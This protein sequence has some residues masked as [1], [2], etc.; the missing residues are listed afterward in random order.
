MFRKMFRAGLAVICLLSLLGAAPGALARID[1]TDGPAP[2]A[3]A[4]P[5][6]VVR[7]A[8]DPLASFEGGVAGL[9]GTR[10]A[11]GERLDL[12]SAEAQAYAA[13][14]DGLRTDFKNWLATH[15]TGAAVTREYA[16]VFNGLAVRLNGLDPSLLLAAPGVAAVTPAYH[17]YPDMNV[18]HSLV[19]APDLW[20]AAGGV[21]KA[22]EGI[23]VGV[24]D[25]GIDQ[26]HHF[27]KDSKLKP[28][29]GYPKGD[30][31]FTSSKVIVARVFHADPNFTPE[32]VN[33]HGTHVAG[34]IAGVYL[35]SSSLTGLAAPPLT[36]I[37]PK[38]FLGNYNVFPGDVPS[39]TIDAVIAA[40]EEA[41]IDGMDVINMSL[42]A[43]TQEDDDPL[44]ATVNAAVD[45]GVVMAVSAGNS[46]PGFFTVGTPAIAEKAISVA[47]S[48]NPHF[49]GVSV[50]V[51]GPGTVPDDL[52]ANP[53]ATGDGGAELHETAEAVY[54]DWDAIDGLG[55]GEACEPLLFVGEPPLAGKIALIRRGTCFFSTKINNAAAAGA[56]AVI[57]SNNVDGDPVGMS[58]AEP[59][60]T[61]AVMVALTVGRRLRE[62]YAAN[63]GTAAVRINADT[64]E[65]MT[66]N[67]DVIA[68]FSSRGPTPG[69][70]LKPDLA[71]PGVDIYS[72]VVGGGFAAF[73]GTSM[74][75]PH[76]A[77]AAAVLRQVYPKWSP[78]Q[79]KSALVNTAV[80]VRA[81][82]MPDS[83]PAPVLAV[84][85]GRINLSA[86]ADPAALAQPASLG[87]GRV[88]PESGLSAEKVV[89][90]TNPSRSARTYELSVAKSRPS[91]GYSAA[92]DRT[93]VTIAAGGSAFFRVR[94]D[95]PLLMPE[96]DYQG[97][98]TVTDGVRTIRLPFWFRVSLL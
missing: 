48:T 13:Y 93:S 91:D 41:V 10:P 69:Y 95:V 89:L 17:V 83:P 42:G 52:H 94:L 61:P 57:I 25:S 18:S 72:S 5:V 88:F 63:P 38:A 7:L 70:R 23:K 90:L 32:A 59:V 51:L 79:V 28:P 67:G 86:A 66:P 85:G 50:N 53:A 33:S 24:I 8:G 64:S 34:T 36:G 29:K 84:G 60:N 45:A 75:A 31:R 81:D 16:V 68:A 87:F 14:L 65:V 12:E 47:A 11:D 96:G 77:G 98:V 19:G 56:I 2:G 74:A 55:S 49:F 6:V 82:F 20:K 37:A 80:P 15:A 39:A 62:W 92:V 54:V 26:N 40:V 73:Q 35:T 1:P 9:S 97:F 44:A 21:N 71:A 22:G 46:G 43:S 76:V 58:M 78:A 4:S 27:L 30:T 3:S